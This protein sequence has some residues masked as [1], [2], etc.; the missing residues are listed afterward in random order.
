MRFILWVSLQNSKYLNT[1]YTVVSQ[2]PLPIKS[3]TM[4]EHSISKVLP[5]MLPIELF[6]KSFSRICWVIRN[7]NSITMRTLHSQHHCLC[8]Q[9]VCQQ[10]LQFGTDVAKDSGWVFLLRYLSHRPKSFATG[11]SIS[12]HKPFGMTINMET[13]PLPVLAHE[14][15]RS[16][17][18]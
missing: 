11:D 18:A 3:V 7:C 9:A 8:H 17:K 4:I 14:A 5:W 13:M 1:G 12:N 16:S 6:Q 15:M 10:V 2:R